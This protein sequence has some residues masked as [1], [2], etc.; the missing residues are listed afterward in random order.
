MQMRCIFKVSISH[1]SILSDRVHYHVIEVLSAP[2]IC[3]HRRTF[4]NVGIQHHYF[5]PRGS[6]FDCYSGFSR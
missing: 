4:A 2:D 1:E 6:T 3:F 5:V